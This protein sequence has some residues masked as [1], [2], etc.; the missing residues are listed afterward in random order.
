MSPQIVTYLIL[1]ITAV[2]LGY[3]IYSA[4]RARKMG[5][6]ISFQPIRWIGAALVFCLAL[7]AVVTN[8]TYDDLIDIING[9]FE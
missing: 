6:R 1:L 3:T 9:W 7:V 2:Y 8:M 5:M 4:R